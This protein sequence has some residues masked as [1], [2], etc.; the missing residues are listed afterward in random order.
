MRRGVKLKRC[1]EPKYAYEVIEV[2]C[3]YFTN[4]DWL[5]MLHI[6]YVIFK[7]SSTDYYYAS[8]G[9]SAACCIVGYKVDLWYNYLASLK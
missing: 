7:E 5:D 9:I 4:I 2:N 1:V 6:N 3:L 8:R